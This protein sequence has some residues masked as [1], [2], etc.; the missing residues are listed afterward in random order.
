MNLIASA[1]AAL[2]LA[3]A[4]RA[5]PGPGPGTRPVT[6]LETHAFVELREIEAADDKA[7]AEVDGWSRENDA[8]KTKPGAQDEA[9]LQERIA[10]RVAPVRKA[11]E[12]FLKRYPENATAHL[13]FGS[14]LNDRHEERAAQVQWEKALE[15]DPRNPATYHNLACRYAESGP[16]DKAFAYFSRAIELGPA[17]S[18]YSHSF[19]DTLFVLRREAAAYYR[20]TEQEI[21]TK[22]LLLYSNALRLDPTNFALARDF[23]QTYYPIKPLPV[24]AAL[25][26]WTNAQR[27][28]REEADREDACIHLARVKML[29]GRFA[30]ARLQLENVTNDVWLKSK[31]TLLQHIAEREK[32]KP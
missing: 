12:D 4:V 10:K 9:Q 25:A 27:I 26:A 17:E 15:L 5:E 31:T 30:D 1:A 32:E 13:L 23:A 3:T 18:V 8:L 6:S 11:Y 24:E 16:V 28:A 7:Q 22:A 20:V 29:A 14:F 2:V 19:A 21:Y